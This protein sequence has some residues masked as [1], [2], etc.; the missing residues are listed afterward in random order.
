MPLVHAGGLHSSE[1][2]AGHCL[3]G[4]NRAPRG[5]RDL[6]PGERAER[7]ALTELQREILSVITSSRIGEGE[8]C[9]AGGT[10]RT[11]RADKT[12]LE[13]AGFSISSIRELPGFVE[14]ALGKGEARTLVQWTVDSAY[15]F[16]PLVRDDTLGLALHPFDLA[17]NKV[18]A[19][20]GRLEARDWIDVIGCPSR[21][22]ELGSLMEAAC[23]K[24]PGLNPELILKDPCT[25]GRDRRRAAAGEN[26]HLCPECGGRA[27]P[28]RSGGTRER[29]PRS[30]SRI[31]LTT[32]FGGTPSP[33]RP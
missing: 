13:R 23:G 18:L 4:E 15:R 26:R 6:R 12:L 19:L 17:T 28:R 10:A 9:V 8:S 27:V 24:D 2:I 16:F 5:Q 32:R 11:W 33:R 14:A 30:S 20:V 31:R 7:M 3:S 25:G 29:R 1:R 22:Q 21:L